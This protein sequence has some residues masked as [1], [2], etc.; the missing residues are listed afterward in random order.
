MARLE[1]LEGNVARLPDGQR[2][3]IEIVYGNGNVQ[4]RYVGGT[5]DGF[6]TILDIDQVLDESG[7]LRT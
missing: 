1:D 5:L 7:R 4:V 3:V 2:V 6:T